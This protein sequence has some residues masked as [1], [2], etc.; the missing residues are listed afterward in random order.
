[1]SLTR[2]SLAAAYA[3]ADALIQPSKYEP[4]ALTVGEALASGMP[5]VASDE[6]GA[7]EGIDPGCCT[8]FRSGDLDA[9]ESAV[10]GLIGRLENGAKPAISQLARSEASGI[11]RRSTLPTGLRSRWKGA[12]R[13][14]R[15]VSALRIQRERNRRFVPPARSPE[16]VPVRA[17]AAVASA[18]ADHR[19]TPSGRCRHRGRARKGGPPRPRRYRREAKPECWRPW[20]PG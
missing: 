13:R 16:A 19:R 2:R 1:M 15:R 3:D 18:G 4:F 6:V 11:F 8:V 9:F 5:V 14:S 17:R 20:K 7:A 10:R 12:D